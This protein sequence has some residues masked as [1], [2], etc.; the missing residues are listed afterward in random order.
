MIRA[1]DPV[2]F[3]W[4]GGEKEADANGLKFVY[5]PFNGGYYINRAYKGHDRIGAV[6]D[7][8]LSTT[9]TVNP[10]QLQN[11]IGVQ[12]TFWTEQVDRPQDLEYLA[13]PRLLG[14]AE[15]G[16]SPDVVKDYDDFLRRAN[17]ETGYLRLAGFNYG[18]HQLVA[19]SA[20]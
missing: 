15:Q 3:C 8:A 7:G 14:I 5:T 11:C 12:G 4:I 19:P 13:I 9:L 16:W 2:I 1:I 18:A 17:L 20:E 6:G 10:P